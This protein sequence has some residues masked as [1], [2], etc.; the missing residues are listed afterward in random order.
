M[1]DIRL[2]GTP[3]VYLDEKLLTIKRR[4]TRALLFYLAANQEAISRP[5]LCHFLW[6]G[7]GEETEQRKKLRVTLNNLKKALSGVDIIRT[8]HDT[9]GLE[10]QNLRVDLHDFSSALSKTQNYT[11]GFQS[12]QTI[13]INLYQDLVKAANSWRSSDFIDNGDMYLSET[14]SNWW[15]EKN[16]E[17]KRDQLE[18]FKFLACLEDAFGKPQKAISWAEKVLAVNDYEEEAHFIL[19]RNLQI[20]E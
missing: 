2:L 14:A 17:L 10:R 11:K 7:D 15:S 20:Q 18:L 4:A 1:L 9:L 16:R 3:Q 13:P 19:L 5:Q 12:G 8:Y 6:G